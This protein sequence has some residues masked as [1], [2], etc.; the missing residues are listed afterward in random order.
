[1][2]VNLVTRELVGFVQ[3]ILTTVGKP[4]SQTDL[5]AVDV[6]DALLADTTAPHLGGCTSF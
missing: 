3:K 1:M 5:M 6:Q 2:Y 4:L